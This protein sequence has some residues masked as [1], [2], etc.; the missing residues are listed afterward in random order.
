MKKGLLLFLLILFLIPQTV[1]AAPRDEVLQ[2]IEAKRQEI[3]KRLEER[4]EQ[5]R[6]LVAS[7]AAQI[8]ARLSAVKLKVCETHKDNIERRSVNLVAR[9]ERHADVFD[10]ITNRVD[11]FYTEK[12]VPEG[13]TLASYDALKADIAAQKEDVAAAIASAQEAI[14]AFDCSGENPKGQLGLYREEMK[15][16]IAALKDYREAVKNFIVAVKEAATDG[17]TATT[18]A[19]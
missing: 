16:V 9:A 19:N 3:M 6:S 10:S 5:R 2:R 17:G 14:E 18:S 13:K 1:S 12:L 11:R 4:K 15:L 8:R 7:K